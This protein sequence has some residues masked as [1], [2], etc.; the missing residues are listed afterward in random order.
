MTRR[1]LLAYYAALWV[2]AVVTVGIIEA[3]KR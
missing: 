2:T 3:V 1:Q